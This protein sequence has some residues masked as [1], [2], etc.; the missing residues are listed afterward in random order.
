MLDI[1]ADLISRDT[2]TQARYRHTRWQGQC[3]PVVV[4]PCPRLPASSPPRAGRSGPDPFPR[5]R[6]GARWSRAR[7]S[8]RA[9]TPVTRGKLPVSHLYQS[10]GKF[11]REPD[12]DCDWLT[13]MAPGRGLLHAVMV[14]AAYSACLLRP[15]HAFTALA[16]AQRALRC[17]ASPSQ[18]FG[19]RN[20]RQPAPTRQRAHPCRASMSLGDVLLQPQ[21]QVRAVLARDI[22]RPPMMPVPCSDR[23]S[24]APAATGFALPSGWTFALRWPFSWLPRLLC[25]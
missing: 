10:P 22:R 8:G 4:L 21:F 5:S 3:G 1:P 25:W 6:P 13:I 18:G 14:G 11:T 23:R 17:S 15:C 2:V 20:V 9:V 7:S 16:P 19:H 12:R 24:T